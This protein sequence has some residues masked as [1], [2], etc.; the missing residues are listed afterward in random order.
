MSNPYIFAKA[1]A[2]STISKCVILGSKKGMRFP[3]H[4]VDWSRLR[5]GVAMSYTLSGDNDMQGFGTFSIANASDEDKIHLGLM[6]YST[7]FPSANSG[8]YF[9]GLRTAGTNTYM[10]FPY[11]LFSASTGIGDTTQIGV[12]HKNGTTQTATGFNSFSTSPSWNGTIGYCNI[13]TLDLEILNKNQSNQQI[14]VKYAEKTIGVGAE[15]A[16]TQANIQKIMD[17]STYTT[18]GTFDFQNG[19]IPYELPDCYFVY[20]PMPVLSYRVFGFNVIRLA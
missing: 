10:D 6:R 4:V 13:F 15:A 7:K 9:L 3:F 17:T 1:T 14:I 11:T 18:A 2:N 19:G 20:F 12:V 8:Q 5:V 16:N